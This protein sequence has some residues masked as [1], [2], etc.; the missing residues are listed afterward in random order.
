MIDAADLFRGLFTTSIDPDEILISMHFPA[1]ASR[2]GWSCVELARRAGDYAVC[3]V[4][5]QVTAADNGEV[6]KARVALF[7][8]GTRPVRALS[9]EDAITGSQLTPNVIAGASAVAGRG[10]APPDDLRGSS[11]YRKH[12]TG[13]LTRRALEDAGEKI[14]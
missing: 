6:A 9:V 11:E 1:L 3:G 14:K 8:V 12:L 13:V 7:G 4:V 2:S 10:L 5:A